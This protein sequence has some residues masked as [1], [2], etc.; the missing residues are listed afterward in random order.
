M[1]E[2]LLDEECGGDNYD[3][4]WMSTSTKSSN[5]CLDICSLMIV[6]S[7]T[8]DAVHVKSSRMRNKDGVVIRL[9]STKCRMGN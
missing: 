5:N 1:L 4:F 9:N 6:F 3:T 2:V 7:Q 8:K